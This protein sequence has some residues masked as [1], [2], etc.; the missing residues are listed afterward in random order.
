MVNYCP[1]CGEKVEEDQH[2]CSNCGYD[3]TNE[4]VSSNEDSPGNDE[5]DEVEKS[6]NEGITA[7]N[8]RLDSLSIR[9]IGVGGILAAFLLLGAIFFTQAPLEKKHLNVE[10]I[11]WI[12]A[13]PNS[14]DVEGYH[15]KLKV[16]LEASEDAPKSFD[17][18]YYKSPNYEKTVEK[19]VTLKPGESERVTVKVPDQLPMEFYIEEE[20][21]DAVSAYKPVDMPEPD[22]SKVRPSPDTKDIE[23]MGMDA[24]EFQGGENFKF[25]KDEFAENEDNFDKVFSLFVNTNETGSKYILP[26]VNI[27]YKPHENLQNVEFDSACSVKYDKIKTGLT[28]SDLI[29]NGVEGNAKNY[30]FRGNN[31]NKLKVYFDDSY[32]DVMFSS[33]EV[34][35]NSVEDGNGFSLNYLFYIEPHTAFMSFDKRSHFNYIIC[36]TTLT[37]ENGF[38]RTDKFRINLG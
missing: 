8:L 11:E 21:S 37:A 16:T 7:A 33:K 28:K 24:V 9:K 25:Q 4:E 26:A 30:E 29:Y 18:A 2:Y 1:E 15:G 31:D 27:K 5:K 22:S 3:L 20:G 12:D 14:M 38:T 10:N 35:K 19:E 36:N 32:G 6:I 23:L 13:Y 17:V 34:K